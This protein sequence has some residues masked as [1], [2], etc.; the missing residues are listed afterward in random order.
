MATRPVHSRSGA[1]DFPAQRF[2]WPANSS[3]CSSSYLVAAMRAAVIALILLGV[4]ALI[5]LF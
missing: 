4:L 1:Q 5:V 3:A 2:S